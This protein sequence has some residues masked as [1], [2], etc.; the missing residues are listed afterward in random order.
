MMKKSLKATILIEL[1][2]YYYPIVEVP[3]KHH[4]PY[5]LLIA[6]LLSQQSTDKKVNEITPLL[7]ALADTPQ[8][9]CELSEEAIKETIRPIGLAP[10]KASNIRQ[11]S[12]M[13][14]KEFD[15]VVPSTVEELT[16]LPGVGRKTAL[17]VLAQAFG[18]SAFP[19]DTHI[20]RLSNR[21]GL[22]K[23]KNPLKVEEDLKKVFP[24][25]GWSRIHLQ[26]IFAGRQF[27]KAQPHNPVDCP[28]CS[29]VS[30]KKI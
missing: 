29:R 7:F 20:L 30:A 2:E 12:F 21:W 4:S 19:V 22:S 15:G 8:K 11:L 14:L 9:M 18:Q 6:V 10:Q 23:S 16:R 25:S 1:F 27:C 3:L 5:T 17:C 13:L 28:F 26:I 24:K